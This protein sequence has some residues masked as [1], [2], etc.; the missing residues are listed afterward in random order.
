MLIVH[1]QSFQQV[2]RQ[3][4]LLYGVPEQNEMDEDEDKDVFNGRL[5]PID[6]ILAENAPET[7]TVFYKG[8][9][10]DRGKTF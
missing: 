2:I 4:V 10:E 3:V 5:V 1:S 8:S 6:E 7:T 9:V